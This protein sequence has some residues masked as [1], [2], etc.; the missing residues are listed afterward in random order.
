MPRNSDTREESEL[1]L[2]DPLRF[3]CSEKIQGLPSRGMGLTL[4]IHFAKAC[5]YIVQLDIIPVV[6]YS[7]SLRYA[8]PFLLFGSGGGQIYC[9]FRVKQS[10][11]VRSG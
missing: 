11:Y 8:S 7:Y 9:T 6:Q 3:R 10:R 5:D 4:T 1:T 2:A